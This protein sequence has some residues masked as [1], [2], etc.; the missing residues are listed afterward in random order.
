MDRRFLLEG[1]RSERL[2]VETYRRLHICERFF[3]SVAFP[4]D[5]FP[6]P[7]GYATYPSGC[8]STMILNCFI[9]LSIQVTNYILA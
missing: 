5:N 2:Y 3:I 6:K 8:F 4:D 1:I 7:S 9:A